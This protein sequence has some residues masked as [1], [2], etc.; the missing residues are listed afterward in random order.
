VWTAKHPDGERS[1]ERVN[2]E[3]DE[4][5]L[6][7]NPWEIARRLYWY[8]GSQ[9]DDVH[10]LGEFAADFDEWEAEQLPIERDAGGRPS[11]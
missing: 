3:L 2:R 5:R 8:L 4:L 9:R 1:W 10:S 11:F 7:F 6:R